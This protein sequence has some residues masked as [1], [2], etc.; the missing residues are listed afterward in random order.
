MKLATRWM[1][2]VA[3]AAVPVLTAQA[4]RA[5]E[6]PKRNLNDDVLDILTRTAREEKKEAPKSETSAVKTEDAARPAKPA[7]APAEKP[8]EKPVAPAEAPA[9]KPAETKPAESKPAPPPA[10]SIGPANE[11]SKPADKPAEKPAADAH[12]GEHQYTI[13]EGDTFSTIAVALYRD[14]AKWIAIAQ[15]NPLVD[16]KHLKVGQVI[17]LPDLAT[18]ERQREQQLDAIKEA[19]AKPDGQTKTVLVQP[20]D[21]LSHI[22]VRV[23]G[24]A[25]LWRVIFEANK[26]ELESP[27]AL[28]VG[29]KLTIPPKPKE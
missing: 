23:Y 4:V 5:A 28:K 12:P 11:T 29:M 24:K 2:I 27:D 8:A 9:P 26:A 6:E 18:F 25:S 10:L 17:R 14:E 15:A 1:L 20:G 7:E 22:A 13:R 19:V 16:P 3:I 21:T